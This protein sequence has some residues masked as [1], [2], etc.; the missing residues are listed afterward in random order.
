[1]EGVYCR[2]GDNFTLENDPNSCFSCNENAKKLKNP[3]SSSRPGLNQ[4]K[5]E[6]ILL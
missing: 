6:A 3:P 2:R 5:S 4:Q 1:M